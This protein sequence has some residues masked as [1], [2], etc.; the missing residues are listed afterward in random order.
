[1]PLTNIDLGDD[2]V[3]AAADLLRLFLLDLPSPLLTH[4]LY[5]DF[6]AASYAG[7]ASHP[8]ERGLWY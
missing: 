1:V 7:L 4:S 8:R 5:D 6:I 3:A 2:A